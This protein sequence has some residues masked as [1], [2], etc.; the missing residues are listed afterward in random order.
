[1]IRKLI[2]KIK[3]FIVNISQF[4][5]ATPNV[6]LFKYA[7]LKFSNRYL[8]LLGKLYYII[9]RKERNII[10]KNIREVIKDNGSTDKIIKDT[11][12]GIF[13]H[14]SEKLCM[15]YRNLERL[16][17]EIGGILE[18]SGLDYLDKASHNGGVVLVTGHFGAVEYLPLALH[19]R[20][21]PVSMTVSFQTE[22]LKQSLMKRANE[23]D[24]EL[25]DCRN[26]DIM[27]RVLDALKRGRILLT[28]CD[29]VDAWRT[30]RNRTIRA[31]GGEIKLDRS[32]GVLYRRTGAT[33]LGSFML[34]TDKGY[35]MTI[36]PIMNGR[37][38][39][40]SNIAEEILK[41]FE[42]YVL[43]FPDQWYQW[44]KLDK[45]RPEVV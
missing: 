20:N 29:E 34:R 25:I 3:D 36:V 44:K 33:V 13:S 24:V 39:K 10:E 23:G 17:V 30:H 35:K 12:D 38:S 43:K 22:Q 21:Y 14:Y 42:N 15:A 19:L 16:K 37:N 26:D 8:R 18:Y 2:A 27:Q 45:M 28:E 1:M 6:L 31:F 5:Q 9:N 11:F 32:L 41:T 40:S 7:P 4:L